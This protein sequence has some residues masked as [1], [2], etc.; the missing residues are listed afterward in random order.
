MRSTAA[1]IGRSPI[2]KRFLDILLAFAALVVLSPLMLLLAIWIRV[3]MGAPVL[4]K[5]TRPGL[6]GKP[7]TMYK[8]RTMTDAR[9]PQGNLL[10][11]EQRLT[12]LGQFLRSTSLDELPELINVLK[13][14]MSLVGPRPLLMAYL[15]RYSPEQFRRHEVRPGITGWAQVNGRNAISWKAKFKLDVWYV[16]NWNLWLDIKI[17]LMTLVK[18]FRREGIGHGSQAT[19]PEFRGKRDT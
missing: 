10:P 7:F 3:T 18:V 17:L 13:G 9:D 4:F 8:F 19:M 11:D 14:E 16:D 2:L 5:Q 15:D 12:K 6:H 1:R